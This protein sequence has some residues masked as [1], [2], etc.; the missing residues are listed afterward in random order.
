MF[1]TVLE[2]LAFGLGPCANAFLVDDL[3]LSRDFSL[4][5]LDSRLSGLRR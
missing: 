3:S 4:D 1:G 2:D 5:F